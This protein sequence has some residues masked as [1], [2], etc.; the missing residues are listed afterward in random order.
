MTGAF[1]D[2]QLHRPFDLCHQITQALNISELIAI[3]LDEQNRFA[4]FCQKTKLI[5]IHG[6]SD[7]NQSPNTPVRNPDI[8]AHARAEGK[9]AESDL[10]IGIIF[11]QIVE[12]GPHVIALAATF[13]V[14]PGALTDAAKV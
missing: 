4:R 11:G 2:L 1:D 13:V 14:L 12:P 10:L 8:E 3:A 9:A 6:C 7:A 5:L